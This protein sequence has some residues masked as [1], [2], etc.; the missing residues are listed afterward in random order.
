M[1]NLRSDGKSKEVK[2]QM[3]TNSIKKSKTGNS[4][5]F[6]MIQLSLNARAPRK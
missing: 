5:N 4:A 2:L 1:E 3:N 6:V